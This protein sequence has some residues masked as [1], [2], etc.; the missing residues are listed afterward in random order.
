MTRFP[1]TSTLS[2]VSLLDRDMLIVL[3]VL[4]CT[5]LAGSTPLPSAA[6]LPNDS[7]DL[8]SARRNSCGAGRSTPPATDW[9]PQEE[10]LRNQFD[11]APVCSLM[12]TPLWF[13]HSTSEN[14]FTQVLE[15]N[16]KTLELRVCVYLHCSC[17]A[18]ILF[19]CTTFTVWFISIVFWYLI[20]LNI[21]IK[22]TWNNQQ[23]HYTIWY[24][25]ENS[26]TATQ[27]IN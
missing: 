16:L 17:K 25:G 23:I 6:Q 8:S 1:L 10:S 15:Y 9:L 18:N 3:L 24:P 20:T 19:Y 22:N 5:F 4:A 26:Q 7:G 21:Q 27:Y 12:Y 14:T 13:R 11:M 2:K